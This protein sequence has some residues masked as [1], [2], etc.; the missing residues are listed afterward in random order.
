MYE[1]K[2]SDIIKIYDGD[3]ITVNVD[4]GFGVSKLEKFRLA[5]INTPELRGDSHDAGIVSRDYLRVLLF[6][7]FE[8][9]QTITIKTKK[10]RKGKYGRYTGEVFINGMSVNEKMLSEGLAVPYV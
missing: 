4:L 8:T 5:Y 10:D 1:Y 7:A 3:T 9:N 6:T 2:V